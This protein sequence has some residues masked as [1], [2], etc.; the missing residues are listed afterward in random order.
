MP[1]KTKAQIEAELLTQQEESGLQQNTGEN[2]PPADSP[3]FEDIPQEVLS[4]ENVPENVPSLEPSLP[5]L[6]EENSA[7]QDIPL[8]S[9]VLE[10]ETPPEKEASPIEEPSE[11]ETPPS[12]KEPS[13]PRLYCGYHSRTAGIH[14]QSVH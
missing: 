4:A 1:R 13:P 6:E 10:P 14:G 3:A 12:P 2:T 5:P 9:V 7:P 8:Y 11:K